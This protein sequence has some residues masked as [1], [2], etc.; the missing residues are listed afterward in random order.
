VATLGVGDGSGVLPKC[1]IGA[2]GVRLSEES[3]RRVCSLHSR[4][5]SVGRRLPPNADIALAASLAV[6]GVVELA[7]PYAFERTTRPGPLALHIAVAVAIAGLLIWRRTHPLLVAP[8]VE[9]LLVL[10]SLVVVLPNVYVA[11]VVQ[12]V[13][14]YSLA[15][16]APGWRSAAVPLAITLAGSAF[17]GSRDLS[18]PVG[19]AAS[20]VIFSVIVLTAGAVVRR[21]RSR[22][23]SMRTQRDLAAAEVRAVAAEERARIARE[24]HDVVAHGMSVVALQ[25]V[26]GRRMLDRNPEQA[27]EAF[28]TI[29]RVTSDCL[30][31]MRRLLGIL[32]ADEDRTP[33][34]PQPT[35]DQV[36]GLV[37]LARAAGAV[38]E[39]TVCG[40]PRRL[41]PGVDLSAY[42]IAQEALTNARKHAPGARVGLRISYEESAVVVEVVD[43][44]PGCAGR[45]APGHGLIGMRERVE[46]FGGTLE[47]GPRSEGGFG[48]RARLPLGRV[49]P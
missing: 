38:V 8:A 42:R 44:G 37:Q 40:D 16:Y 9:S 27:R 2:R 21:Y 39:L 32:R 10:E 11:A 3:A 43:D 47:A 17:V 49:L 31:E 33:L 15:V 25:A 22:T 26:G 41:P 36:A 35:L 48:V 20:N 18:D 23:E 30:E 1:R 7:L 13:A 14:L 5:M 19:S 34:A 29:A 4:A 46:L 45:P 6:L 24:L 12:I 28:D